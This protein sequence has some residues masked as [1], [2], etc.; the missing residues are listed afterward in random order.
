LLNYL[1]SGGH[2][3]QYSKAQ[4]RYED[5]S[6]IYKECDI[7]VPSYSE[8]QIHTENYHKFN[9]RYIAEGAN[10]P[11][12]PSAEKLL[13]EK[14]II[15]LPDILINSGGVIT[16]YFEWIKNLSHTQHGLLTK[17]WEEKR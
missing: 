13:K 14:G 12:T 7:Y 9:C 6:A 17:R 2:I 1:E 4:Y 15:F 10:Q 5:E 8:N 3:A 16:S 11:V